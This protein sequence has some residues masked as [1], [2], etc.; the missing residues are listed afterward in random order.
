MR[1]VGQSQE[2][3]DTVLWLCSDQ[4]SFV[5]GVVLPIDG[6]QAAG[7]KP[8]RRMYRQGEAMEPEKAER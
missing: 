5:T 6:G 8:E 2:V 1:R 4:S 3:A 7:L